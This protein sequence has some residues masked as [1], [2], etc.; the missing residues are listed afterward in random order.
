MLIRAAER[1]AALRLR[2]PD[3][4]FLYIEGDTQTSTC[5]D[6]VLLAPPAPGHPPLTRDGLRDHLA[7]RLDRVPTLR[8]RLVPVPGNLG[9]ASWADD[10]QFDVDRHVSHHVLDRTSARGEEVDALHAHLATV[11]PRR[12]DL[13]R[14]LW[15]VQLVDGLDGGRQALVFSFHHTLAD[16]AGLLGIL[17]ELVDDRVAGTAPVAP[18]HDRAPAPAPRPVPHLLG[19]LLRLAV[20]MCL[21]PWLVFRSWRRLKAV[22]ARREEAPVRVPRMAADAPRTVFDVSNDNERSYARTVV[23]LDDLRAV[24]RAAGTSLSDVVVAVV[25]GALRDHLTA[26]DALPEVPLVVNVPLGNDAP[27]ATTRLRGNVFVNYYALLPTDVA[28]P[29]ERLTATAAYGAEARLQLEIQ[30]RDTLT[31][32][33]DRIPPALATRA[34]AGMAARAREGSVAPDFNVLVSNLRIPQSGW[35]MGGRDVEQVFMSGP[36]ADGAGLN[37]TVTG[38]GDAVTFAL[39]A[40]PAAVPDVD[41]LAGRFDAALAELLRAYDVGPR[42][43]RPSGPVEVA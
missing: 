32:W 3:S 6:V 1:R 40:N 15:E 20:S 24:R 36:V 26:V 19:A 4:G 37:V 17:H 11:S 13:G 43:L 34:A 35:R 18:E 12:L 14:A 21:L 2:G 28:D 9:H 33:L 38:Y 27:G 25:A 39:H 10:P 31:D 22:R 8:R 16:G 23:P 30:G 41:A 42:R 5:V 29:R 7:V